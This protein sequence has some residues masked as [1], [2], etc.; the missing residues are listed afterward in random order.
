MTAMS[1]KDSSAEEAGFEFIDGRRTF[2]VV[3]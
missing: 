2:F 1:K 3:E